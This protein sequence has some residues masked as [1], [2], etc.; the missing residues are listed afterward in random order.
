[1]NWGRA[2]IFGSSE[3]AGIDLEGSR[4]VHDLLINDVG[5]YSNS[6]NIMGFYDSKNTKGNFIGD[7]DGNTMLDLCSMEN[8]PLGHNHEVFA[9]NFN[10]KDWDKFTI[11]SGLDASQRATRVVSEHVEAAMAPSKSCAKVTITQGSNAVEQ[12]IFSAMN[13]RGNGQRQKVMGFSGANAGSLALGNTGAL[14]WP[15]L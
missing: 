15:T 3:A 9:S 14:G 1:M 2:G 4:A 8:L 6:S 12:A 13:V 5:A 11:N 10:N 7:V